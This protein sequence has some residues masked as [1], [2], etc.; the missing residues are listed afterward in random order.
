VIVIGMDPSLTGF[1]VSD[2]LRTEVYRTPA[3]QSLRER[4]NNLGRLI[5]LFLQDVMRLE[6]DVERLIVIEAPSFNAKSATTNLYDRGYL[7]SAIDAVADDLKFRVV[8][9]APTTLKKFVCGKGNASK[10]EVP[11]H[12]LKKWAQLFERDPGAN[13]AEAY[14][15]YRYGLA[16]RA[17]E[18]QLVVAKKRGA[19]VPA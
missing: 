8:E 14:A 5:S 7:R 4:C 16:F 12:V 1:G 10:M 13:K 3:N 18:V 9:I 6:F 19:K 15:L 11:V 2:G 17:G